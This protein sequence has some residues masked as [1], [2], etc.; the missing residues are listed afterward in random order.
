MGG[1]DD[2][3]GLA[4]LLIFC[5]LDALSR[6]PGGALIGGVLGC[7]LF[8]GGTIFFVVWAAGQDFSDDTSPPPPPP[9]P[10]GPAGVSGANGERHTPTDTSA[11]SYWTN[12]VL[13]FVVVSLLTTPACWYVPRY[14]S[15]A[16]STAAGSP[17]ATQGRA[18]PTAAPARGAGA[19]PLLA[20]RVEGSGEGAG[21]HV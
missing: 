11:E 2:G 1:R 4:L 20:L 17:G 8:V 13:I 9:L 16:T 10:S 15:R 7:L 21:E 19:R 6:T 12:I 18:A 14:W 3:G 5:G